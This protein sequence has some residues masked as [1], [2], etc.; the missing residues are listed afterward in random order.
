MALKKK[1]YLIGA[2]VVVVGVVVA[3]AAVGGHGKKNLEVQTAKV[4]RQKIV[5]KVSATGKI[6]PKTQVEISA[7]VS[8]K[9]VKLPVKEGQ[10]VEKGALLVSLAQERYVAALESAQAN[11]SS[12]H[13]NATLVRLNMNR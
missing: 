12:A 13:A 4:D 7:D 2:A 9:I 8:A 6:Q 3:L 1:H 10:W 5:Q 11:A